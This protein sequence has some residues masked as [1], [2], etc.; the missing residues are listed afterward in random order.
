M[1]RPTSFGKD[2]GLQIR[3]TVTMFL[4]GLLYV[5]LIVTL[6]AV[7]TNGVTVA[8]I[9]GGLAALNLFASDKLALAAMGARVVSPQEAPRPHAQVGHRVRDHGHH[10]AAEPGRAR[11]RDGARAHARRQPRRAGDDAGRLLRHDRGLH[12]AVR[13][14]LRRRLDGRRRRQ[15]ELP[16]AA[17]RLAGRLRGVVPADAGAVAVPR[18]R[19]R[20]RR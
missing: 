9:A 2:T 14:L 4:L 3:M 8:I 10:G 11:G 5:A 1:P 13:L 15:P 7:G 20:P 16:R 18:V 19:G 6:L 12:R 17:A